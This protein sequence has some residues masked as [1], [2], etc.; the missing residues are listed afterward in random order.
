MKQNKNKNVHLRIRDS[1]GRFANKVFTDVVKI[2]LAASKGVKITES[3]TQNG[4]E[5]ERHKPISKIEKEAKITPEELKQYYDKHRS[6]FEMML[7]SGGDKSLSKNYNQLEQSFNTYKGEIIINGKSVS[8][9]EAKLMLDKFKQHLSISINAVD[10]QTKPLL[11]FDG[12]M[13]I[14][15]P[16][17]DN[18]ENELLE[19]F[20][21]T[22]IEEVYENFS[23]AEITQAL[24]EILD[25]EFGEDEVVIYAS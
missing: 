5:K 13:I 14:E 18:L 3:Y 7:E 4:K 1:K 17:V 24:K 21:E 20:G 10:F 12:K 22:D 9:S 2:E 15:L 19:Y 6:T 23:G 8:K 11:T 16:D 25:E